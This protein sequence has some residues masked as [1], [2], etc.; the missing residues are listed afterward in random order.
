MIRVVLCV[1]AVVITLTLEAVLV[2]RWRLTMDGVP[3]GSAWRYARTLQVPALDG[4][5]HR[6]EA[7]RTYEGLD[8]Q[9]RVIARN[10]MKFEDLR[11]GVVSLIGADGDVNISEASTSRT[12]PASPVTVLFGRGLFIEID[13]D[14][15][16]HE[17]RW[18][19]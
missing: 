3:C 15:G 18:S 8:W 10:V 9:I 13:P 12:G 11:D 14:D 17:W 4:H 16:A 1:I 19:R 7:K 5:W 6:F 2:G